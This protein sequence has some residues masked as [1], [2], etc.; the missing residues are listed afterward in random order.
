MQLYR[1]LRSLKRISP[2]I[3]GE[4]SDNTFGQRAILL[5]DPD[6]ALVDCNTIIA[7]KKCIDP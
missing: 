5:T 3:E 4:I 1:H 2:E 6:L 7:W